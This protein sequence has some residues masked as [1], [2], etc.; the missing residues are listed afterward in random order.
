MHETEKSA[1]EPRFNLAQAVLGF[2]LGILATGCI[3]LIAMA[4]RP[5]RGGVSYLR[6]RMILGVGFVQWIYVLPLFFVLRHYGRKSLA[7][8]LV[9]AALMLLL[10]NQAVIVYMV[11]NP[12]RI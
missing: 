8:G 1:A 2:A 11:R 9:I 4:I 12:I 10:L 5:P 6:I 3:I 7:A